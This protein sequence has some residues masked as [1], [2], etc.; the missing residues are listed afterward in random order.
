MGA[1]NANAFG[2]LLFNLWFVY[3]CVSVVIGLFSE[4]LFRCVILF[5]SELIEG[6]AQHPPVFGI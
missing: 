3:V 2:R 5:T 6:S 4:A 1:G